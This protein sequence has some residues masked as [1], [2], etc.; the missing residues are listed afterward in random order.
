MLNLKN[1]AVHYGGLQALKGISLVVEGGAITCLIGANGAGKSTTL[2][3]I[4][5][6]VALTEGEIR[7]QDRRIDGMDP[8]EIVEMGIGHV[9]EGK[10]LFLEMSIRDNLLTGAYLR[11]DK[12]L[13][14]Q[15]LQ[16][17]YNYFPAA[18]CRRN[19]TR[20]QN[21]RWRTANDRD[22]PGVN[23][24][25][26][27]ICFWMNP[28]WDYPRFLPVKSDPSLKR[29]QIKAYPFCSLNKTQIWPSN[30]QKNAMFW[31]QEAS[32]WKDPARNYKT[33]I[34]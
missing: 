23:V 34:M 27:T 15:D 6:M 1:V 33:T 21:E 29:L 24:R 19:Q 14:E 16:R 32:P 2:R 20:F 8:E 4:S 12:E 28:P 31:K 7:F 25:T 22:R 9:P 10:K 30:W 3:A 18:R 17:V 26:Q 13:I 5:G 11:R